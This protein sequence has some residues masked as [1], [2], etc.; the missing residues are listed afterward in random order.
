[1]YM[2]KKLDL[3]KKHFKLSQLCCWSWQGSFYCFPTH[4]RQQQQQQLYK[5]SQ[6]QF[7]TDKQHLKFDGGIWENS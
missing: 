3:A 6:L 2:Q 1:M 7:L 5:G 4:E